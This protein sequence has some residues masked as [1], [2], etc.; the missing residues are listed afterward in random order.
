M[1]SAGRRGEI[2]REAAPPP[3]PP[4]P[5]RS[6]AVLRRAACCGEDFDR[7]SDYFKIVSTLS[8][9]E[10]D[11][12]HSVVSYATYFSLSKYYDSISFQAGTCFN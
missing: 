4:A 11:K 6:H 1:G 3:R 8:Q 9:S 5:R 10:A 2:A 7:F 12:Y